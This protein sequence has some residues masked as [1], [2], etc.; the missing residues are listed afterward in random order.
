MIFG[1]MAGAL[2]VRPY[3]GG[4][5]A[6][7]VRAEAE[8]LAEWLSGKMTLARFEG[9]G[10][11]L[12]APHSGQG[13][14]IKHIKLVRND[15]LS[16]AAAAEYYRAEGAV[17]EISSG[18]ALPSYAYDSSWHTLAPAVTINLKPKRPQSKALYTVTVSG[19]GYVAVRA[20]RGR[21]PE[22]A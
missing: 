18:G 22:G 3:G 6:Q 13:M 21:P 9:V 4:N 14:E 15:S 7:A 20:Y 2:F 5:D 19:Q 16:N 1:A 10:F 11:R 17:L 12:E 8:A